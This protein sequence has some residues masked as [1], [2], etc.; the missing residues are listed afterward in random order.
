VLFIVVT[1][2]VFTIYAA[3]AVTDCLLRYLEM[4][5]CSRSN[6]SY[7]G[8]WAFKFVCLFG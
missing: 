8:S 1:R 2:K 3:T 7:Y 6:R 4:V 5:L